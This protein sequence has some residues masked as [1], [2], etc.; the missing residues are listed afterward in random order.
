[1]GD[2]PVLVTENPRIVEGAAALGR[3]IELPVSEND[4][5]PTPWD[6][7]LAEAFNYRRHV[8]HEEFVINQLLSKS[9]PPA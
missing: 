7:A 4:C 1:M 9:P 2:S 3:G 6:P 5:G 8:V